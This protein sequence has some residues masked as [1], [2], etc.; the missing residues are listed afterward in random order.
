MTTLAESGICQLKIIRLIMKGKLILLFSLILSGVIYSCSG[1]EDPTPTTTSTPVTAITLNPTSISLKV[2]ESATISATVSPSSAT[3]KKIIWSSSNAS[4]ATVD[5]GKVTAKAAGSADIIA[6]SDDSGIKATCTVTV[7]S[8]STTPENP[9]TTSDLV[10][11]GDYSYVGFDRVILS[12]VCNVEPLPG[13]SVK[14]GIMYSSY[15]LTS[16]PNTV[17][18]EEKDANNRFSCEIKIYTELSIYY[19]RAYATRG[20]ETFYGEI[21]S[22]EPKEI[23]P[24]SGDAIDMGVSVKWASCNLGANKP[25]DL[26]SLYAWGETQ[27]KSS[28]TQNNYKFY[29][30]GGYSKYN[31]SDG[32]TVLDLADDAANA[33]L[34][35]NWR[36]PTYEEYMELRSNCESYVIPGG[37][38]LVSKTTGNILV[39][40]YDYDDSIDG[41]PW[42][43]YWTSSLEDT[44]VPYN[45]GMES[46]HHDYYRY[47]GG[48]IRPVQ[49]SSSSGGNTDDGDKI[50]ISVTDITSSSCVVSLSPNTS[51]T[52]YWDIID[53]YTFD[54]YGGDYVLNYY[55]SYYAEEGELSQH[56]D[57]GPSAYDYTNLHSKTEYVVYAGYCDANGVIKSKVFTKEFIT[58]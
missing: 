1:K 50:E 33:K 56:L 53:K 51:G 7:T 48:H 57:Q 8:E 47:E 43:P 54:Y 19:Y 20:G 42:K 21:K 12:G 18:V 38:A 45:L 10:T 17:E 25:K 37:E 2:G 55:V 30:N 3:N 58:K 9:P 14:F 52:Y 28:Y 16:N 6:L 4:V 22:F 23:T 5:E 35:G 34:G 41:N 40:T 29:A 36:M 11:T 15:D 44:S 39:F 26:G 27:T 49:G 32:K 24:T 13:M 31:S 46:G